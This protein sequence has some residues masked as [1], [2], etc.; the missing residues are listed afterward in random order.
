MRKLLAIF[1][2]LMML[3]G[4]ASQETFESLGDVLGQQ[5]G[6]EPAQVDFLIPESESVEVIRGDSGSLYLCDGYE[7]AVETMTS[8][9]ISKTVET[10]SGYARDCLTVMQT[11]TTELARYECVWTSAGEAGDQVG[12]TVILDDGRYHYCLT[13]TASAEDSGSL[14]ETW[15]EIISSFCVKG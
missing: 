13:L 5:N 15:Q 10:L 1:G 8:G 7:I 2:V 11:G 12:R 9:D 14:Q 3:S 4:C 6:T